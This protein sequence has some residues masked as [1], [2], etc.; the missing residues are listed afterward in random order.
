MNPLV[1]YLADVNTI[2]INLAGMLS[3]SVPCG[4]TQG[5]PIGMQIIGGFF[6]GPKILDIVA[7]VERSNFRLES[8]G[9]SSVTGFA[10]GFFECRIE[11]FIQCYYAF[12]GLRIDNLAICIHC[13]Y[14]T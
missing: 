11:F 9:Q 3:V 13:Y 5:L 14:A 7:A 1:Q 6:D 10:C 4:R 8:V 12:Q 2:P